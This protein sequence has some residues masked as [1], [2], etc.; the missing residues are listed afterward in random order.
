MKLVGKGLR[1][2][3]V[4]VVLLEEFLELLRLCAAL[5]D[6]RACCTLLYFFLQ[7]LLFAACHVN[8]ASLL[9]REQIRI[10]S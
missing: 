10:L 6:V 3:E 5:M 8:F 1:L 9:L 2:E 7:I 4:D